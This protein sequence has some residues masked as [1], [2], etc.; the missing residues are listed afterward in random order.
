MAYTPKMP[1]KRSR[2]KNKK[3]ELTVLDWVKIVLFVVV[4]AALVSVFIFLKADIGNVADDYGKQ[5]SDLNGGKANSKSQF[6]KQFEYVNEKKQEENQLANQNGNK[7]GSVTIDGVTLEGNWRTDNVDG[8]LISWGYLSSVYEGGTLN[9]AALQEHYNCTCDTGVP[10]VKQSYSSSSV[11]HGAYQA[12]SKYSLNGLL[13]GLVGFG[14]TEL[15][16]FILPAGDSK[17]MDFDSRNGIHQ[18]LIKYREDDFV[19]LLSAELKIMMS[20]YLPERDLLA[21][22]AA[23]GKDRYEINPMIPAAIYSI[24]IYAGSNTCKNTIT[25][26]TSSMTDEEII[27]ML[28]ERRRAVKNGDAPRCDN[29][30]QTALNAI[31]DNNFDAYASNNVVGKGEIAYGKIL[32]LEGY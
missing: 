3:D 4:S 31:A 8:Y 32:G 13:T 20:E 17:Y 24:N 25:K 30:K 28:Y 15:E 29:E 12:D 26:I 14:Y 23:T 27:N 19:S 18:L 9:P 5:A 22:E 11:A 2:R 6:N 1:R 16:P 10:N 21:L 7:G